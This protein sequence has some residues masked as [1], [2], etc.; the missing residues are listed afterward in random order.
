MLS[1]TLG[2]VTIILSFIISFV[3]GR[4]GFD[5]SSRFLERGNVIPSRQEA[6]TEKSL[7]AWLKDPPTSQYA[8]PHAFWIIPLDFAFM[9]S[10]AV[11]MATGSLS[12]AEAIAWPQSLKLWQWL[13]PLIGPAVYLLSDAAE[14]ILIVRI[15]LHSNQVDSGV[16]AA[17]RVATAIKVL[18]ATIALLQTLGL[19]LWSLLFSE[20]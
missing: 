20:V 12:F 7:S 13:L 15:L 3:A 8:R 14:D 9:L 1:I 19:G 5:V 11:F 18:S 6:L 10:L 16:F 4:C 17:K 2:A